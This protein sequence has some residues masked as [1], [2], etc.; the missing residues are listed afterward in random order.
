M[1]PAEFIPLAEATGLIV[2]VGE[3]VL[4]PACAQAAG[5]ASRPGCRRCGWR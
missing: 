4:E 2:Q 5:L 1:P 3:W